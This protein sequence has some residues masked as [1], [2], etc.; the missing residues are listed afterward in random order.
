MEEIFCVG[1]TEYTLNRPK[2][3]FSLPAKI[4]S[5]VDFPIPLVPTRPKTWPGLVTGSLQVP[6]ISNC[7]NN[8][9]KSRCLD[10]TKLPV[11]LE[12]IWPIAMCGI[13][14]QIFWKVDDLNGIKWAFLQQGSQRGLL[15]TRAHTQTGRDHTF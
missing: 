15:Y 12:G 1:G 7:T 4:L 8:T 6:E 2:L 10:Q 5:A 3:G 13:L 11:Q 14:F 9:C